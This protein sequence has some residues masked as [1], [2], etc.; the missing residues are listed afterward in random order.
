GPNGAG[1]STTALTLAGLL[2]EFAGQ[3]TAEPALR[4]KTGQVRPFAW[5]SAL[6][7]PRMGMVFQEPAHQFLTAEVAAELRLGPHLAGWSRAEV[8][9]RVGQLL[10]V[11]GLNDLA[12]G[13]PAE[14]VRRREASPVG[15]GD[16]RSPTAGAHRRRTDLRAGRPDLGRAGRAVPRRTVPRLGGRRRQPRPR[17]PRGDRGQAGRPRR[18]L[19]R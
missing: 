4:G 14:P 3:V 19:D 17:L 12:G 8:D 6:L 10:D 13:A 11:L 7:A 2:P 5:P 9:D 1:K 18:V 15:G 16:A